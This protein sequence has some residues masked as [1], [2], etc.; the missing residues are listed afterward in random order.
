MNIVWGEL[1]SMSESLIGQEDNNEG[2]FGNGKKIQ[3]E[4][5]TQRKRSIS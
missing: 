5:K 4:E 3:T 2:N 1:E